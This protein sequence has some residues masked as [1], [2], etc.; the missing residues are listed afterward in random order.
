MVVFESVVHMLLFA[1]NSS[2]SMT[3]TDSASDDETF[4]RNVLVLVA[5]KP[6]FDTQS[7]GRQTTFCADASGMFDQ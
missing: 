6:N 1:I 7:L 3:A 5:N 4:D 2:V